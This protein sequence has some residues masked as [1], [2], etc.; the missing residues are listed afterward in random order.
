M[1]S[2][3]GAYT[4]VTSSNGVDLTLPTIFVCTVQGQMMPSWKPVGLS[5]K[6]VLTG[7]G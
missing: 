5:Q 2:P 7:E 4:Y 1:K 3:G 6:C